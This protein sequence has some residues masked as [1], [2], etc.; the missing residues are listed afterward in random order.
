M[1]SERARWRH[2]EEQQTT[3][4]GQPWEPDNWRVIS[5]TLCERVSALNCVPNEILSRT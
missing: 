2:A 1:K 5:S 3:Y 4:C